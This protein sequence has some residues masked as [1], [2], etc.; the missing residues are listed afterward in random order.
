MSDGGNNLL[1]REE[2]SVTTSAASSSCGV[3]SL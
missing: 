3:T 1:W 2:V